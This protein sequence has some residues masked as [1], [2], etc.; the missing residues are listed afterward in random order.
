MKIRGTDKV[1][2]DK[3]ND[4]LIMNYPSR[5]NKELALDLGVSEKTVQNRAAML[6][7]RKSVEHHKR[8][9]RTARG[10]ESNYQAVKDL[11]GKTPVSFGSIVDRTGL[12][13]NVVKNVIDRL[14]QSSVIRRSNGEK[15][16]WVESSDDFV[17]HWLCRAW[18]QA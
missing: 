3:D 6:G 7:L 8:C 2:A 17:R 12:P 9:G 15:D 14:S 16:S 13:R 10:N 1:W 5:R 4:Y 11:I 18:R